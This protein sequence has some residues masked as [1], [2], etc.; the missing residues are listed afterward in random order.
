MTILSYFTKSIFK[1]RKLAPIIVFSLLPT[2]G[3]G[4]IADPVPES[5]TP[6][7]ITLQIESFVTIPQSNGS[8]PRARI[9]HLKP[10]YDGQGRLAV[11]DLRG[12]FWVISNGAVSEYANLDTTFTAFVNSPGLG[13]GFGSFAFHPEFATNGKFYTSHSESPSAI[14][15]DFSNRVA[16]APVALHG[17]VTEWVATDP[18]AAVFAGTTRELLRV[19]LPGTIHGMQEIAFNPNSQTGD[20]DYGKL[21]ICIGDGQS[22][23][24]GYPLN[25]HRLDSVLGSILRIDPE[26]SDSAN[27]QYGIPAD[28]PWAADGDTDTL[29]EIWAYGFRNP[30]RISWDTGGDGKMLSGDIGEKNIEEVNLIE[31]GRDYG[32]NV[33]EGTFLIN[34]DWENNPQNGENTEVFALPADDDTLGYTYPVAQYDHDDGVAVVGGFVYRGGLAPALEGKYIFGDIRGGE[35]YFVEADT[36]ALGSQAEIKEMELI[37][38]GSVTTIL[39]IGGS[40][41]ADL[42]FGFDEDNELYLLEKSRGMIFK[43]IGANDPNTMAIGGKF[44]NISTRGRVGIN[45]DVLIGGFVIGD[46]DQTVLIQATGPELADAGVSNILLDPV[47][48]VTDTSDPDNPTVVGTNDN[49]QDDPDQ[50]QIISDLWGGNPPLADG[51]LSSAMVLTLPAGSYTGTISGSNGTTGNA[52]FEVYQVDE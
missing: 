26:G 27:G 22:T 4:Q 35:V 43:V 15:V 5:P 36:L 33:R 29:G 9:N 11:N 12:K 34:G 47:L 44:N 52:V 46:D 37:L 8:A 39:Q 21:Y 41:R 19:E 6:S 14:A 51:S 2:L 23:I 17:V 28:N 10:M 49:W 18:A 50:A 20:S 32:W 42:R 3:R 45:D 38:N 24:K 25:T 13:T 48:V 16:A 40:N 1:P 30:H 7:G 31:P